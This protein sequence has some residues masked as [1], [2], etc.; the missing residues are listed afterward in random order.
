M[1]SR[2]NWSGYSA[3]NSPQMSSETVV[4][5]CNQR[6]KVTNHRKALGILTST[7]INR[8]KNKQSIDCGGYKQLQTVTKDALVVTSY[9]SRVLRLDDL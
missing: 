2:T 7:N 1:E 9:K 4:C 5:N 8:L 6:E 3:K